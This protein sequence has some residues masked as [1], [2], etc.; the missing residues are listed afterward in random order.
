[1]KKRK[2]DKLLL[3]GSLIFLGLSILLFIFG[4]L[5]NLDD[6]EQNISILKKSSIEYYNSKKY[7]AFVETNKKI[8]S[9]TPNNSSHQFIASYSCFIIGDYFC[10]M[11]YVNNAL[12]LK[13]DIAYLELK[14]FILNL[15][16]KPVEAKEIFQDIL[17]ESNSTLAKIGIGHIKLQ[18]NNCI[19]AKE[20]F[21]EYNYQ[22]NIK[23]VIFDK[24]NSDYLSQ[25]NSLGIGWC[26]LANNDFENALKQ[27]DKILDNNPDHLLGIINKANTLRWL[28]KY[29]EARDILLDG[30]KIYPN[31]EYMYGE[32]GLIEQEL[33]NLD[34]AKKYFN[35]ALSN[36]NNTYSCP[37]EGLGLIYFME[38]DNEKAKEHLEKSIEI[39]QNLDFEKYNTLAKIYIKEGKITDAKIL[40][41]KSL[42]NNPEGIEANEL[43]KNIS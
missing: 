5:N 41:L 21:F 19:Q 25:M 3:I 12:E 37:Y 9:L 10:S 16:E 2:K 15:Q 7:Y 36:N 27:F 34:Q 29:N 33:G 8:A 17:K 32:L 23:T 30:L 18:E 40:L 22:T 31:S 28:K 43:L 6:N 14:G 20:I 11:E 4:S 1:M 13:N 24:I 26:D 38:G 42:E 39:K 35:Q